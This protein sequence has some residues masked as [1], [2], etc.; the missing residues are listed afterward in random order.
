MK[1][2]RMCI[3]ALVAAALGAPTAALADEPV[4][5]EI[6]VV[7]TDGSSAGLIDAN[8]AR[9]E[10]N[11]AL[12]LREVEAVLE[13]APSDAEARALRL[14]VLFAMGED[15]AV[16]GD[17]DTLAAAQPDAWAD[18]RV[19]YFH[20][21]ALARSG[22]IGAA[23]DR[24]ESAIRYRA[25]LEHAAFYL[26]ALGELRMADHDLDAA[27]LFFRQA[28]SVERDFAHA[29]L[30]LAV[31]HA[32]QG[33]MS[34][35]RAES[36]PVVL[37]S[38]GHDLLD[39]PDTAFFVPEGQVEIYRAIV[40]DAMG[41]SDEAEASLALWASSPAAEGVAPA[42]IEQMRGAFGQRSTDTDVFETGCDS[43][44]RLD[45][46]RTRGRVAVR[47][48]GANIRVAE[49]SDD[50]DFEIVSGFSWGRND[51]SLAWAVV[52]LAWSDDGESLHVLYNSGMSET[53]DLSGASGRSSGLVNYATTDLLPIA[54]GEDPDQILWSGMWGAGALVADR[55]TAPVTGSPSYLP[56]GNS[57]SLGAVTRRGTVVA[58]DGYTLEVVSG[59][60]PWTLVA[61]HPVESYAAPWDVG[62]DGDTIWYAR[63]GM[64]LEYD[65]E[66]MDPLRFAPLPAADLVRYGPTYPW[67]PTAVAVAG[68]DE[69]WVSISGRV[70]RIRM[71]DPEATTR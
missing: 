11:L 30:G 43:I 4:W 42:T 35:A 25:D 3:G 20:A 59:P 44:G 41:S 13:D 2:T 1:P 36:V 66:T 49:I 26:T 54:F 67:T 56:S 61:S 28:I 51:A 7:P 29:R 48:N 38:M 70:A 6:A 22:Q 58:S 14:S 18:P 19:A 21:L 47:C 55:A 63:D 53:L 46:D 16:I 45:V 27:A 17:A 64:L 15:A 37:P 39:E 65:L 52:D 10:S 62:A 24:L 69:V 50:P 57:M 5:A 12:A 71:A 60:A 8:A 9:M 32:R 40:A 31:V 33:R 23:S 68:P 34:D